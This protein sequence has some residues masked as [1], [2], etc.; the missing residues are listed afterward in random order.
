MLQNMNRLADTDGRQFEERRAID[1]IDVTIGEQAA[2]ACKVP[3]HGSQPKSSY[4]G[5]E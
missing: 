5:T 4:P 2:V 3:C 1:F